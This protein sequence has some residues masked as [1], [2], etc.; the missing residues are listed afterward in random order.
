MVADVTDCGIAV[1][2]ELSK[3]AIVINCGD[4][5]TIEARRVLISGTI[6]AWQKKC[7]PCVKFGN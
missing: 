5:V 3:G 1:T 2:K 6:M 7:V 4:S